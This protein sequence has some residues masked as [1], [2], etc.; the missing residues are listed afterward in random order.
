MLIRRC[1][2]TGFF[3]SKLILKNRLLYCTRTYTHRLPIYLAFLPNKMQFYQK[4]YHK[5]RFESIWRKDRFQIVQ[6]SNLW[7]S[8]INTHIIISICGDVYIYTNSIF[9][10]CELLD[11]ELCGELVPSDPSFKALIHCFFNC[12]SFELK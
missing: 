3:Y 5:E 11:S 4:C 2:I 9:F 12:V 1:T 10:V 6:K 8:V 7:K